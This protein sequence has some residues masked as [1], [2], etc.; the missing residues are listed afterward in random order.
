MSDENGSNRGGSGVG[1]VVVL[2]GLGMLGHGATARPTGGD[3]SVVHQIYSAIYIAAGVLALGVGFL[4]EAVGDVRAAL[5]A[6]PPNRVIYIATR[7]VAA[8]F[9]VTAACWLVGPREWFLR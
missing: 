5:K 8:A 3:G 4:I 9:L 2:I 6:E 7:A 1:L